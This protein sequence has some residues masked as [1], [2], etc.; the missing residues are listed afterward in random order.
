M[1][2]H[3]DVQSLLKL[4]ASCTASALPLPLA[5]T[6]SATASASGTASGSLPLAVGSTESTEY[7]VVR[8]CIRFIRLDTI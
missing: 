3:D 4:L 5:V 8:F 1:C 6:G 7:G 2:V